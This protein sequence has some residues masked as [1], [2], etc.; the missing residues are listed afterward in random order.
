MLLPSASPLC[1]VH[2][3][4]AQCIALMPSASLS[5]PVHRERCTRAPVTDAQ[6]P[7][8]MCV[9][10]AVCCT[11]GG[12]DRHERWGYFYSSS[13]PMCAVCWVLHEWWGYFFDTDVCCDSAIMYTT[14]SVSWPMLRYPA[15]GYLGYPSILCYLGCPAIF[16][17]QATACCIHVQPAAIVELPAVMAALPAAAPA[18]HRHEL[19]LLLVQELLLVQFL[20][21]MITDPAAPPQGRCCCATPTGPAHPCIRACIIAFITKRTLASVAI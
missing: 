20:S 19:L 3:P 9:L 8:P 7:T 16:N 13:T 12:A 17:T 4:Y 1:P 5:W 15:A 21:R 11:S 18:Q 14:L 6:S 2:R 10:G